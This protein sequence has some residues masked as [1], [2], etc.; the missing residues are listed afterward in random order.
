[1]KTV[2]T[3]GLLA[4]TIYF[5]PIWATENAQE[6]AYIQLND[7][8]QPKITD[9]KGNEL[10]KKRNEYNEI[11]LFDKNDEEV[12]LQNAKVVL[13]EISKLFFRSAKLTT[14][15]ML[16]L[17]FN[18]IITNS[19]EE[20]TKDEKNELLA[21]LA[22]MF[23]DIT[24]FGFKGV[25]LLDNKNNKLAEFKGFDG[26]YFWGNGTNY[27]VVITDESM[28]RVFSLPS[29]KQNEEL[30]VFAKKVYDEISDSNLEYLTIKYK[31]NQIIGTAS[32]FKNSSNKNISIENKISGQSPQEAFNDISKY[33]SNLRESTNNPPAIPKLDTSVQT[34]FQPLGR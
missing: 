34:G 3:L 16:N 12:A 17:S 20:I 9:L 21:D 22:P 31:W 19:W 8:G 18:R 28:Q 32:G 5:T 14:D 27:T 1:M 6:Q 7:K 23:A 25:N 10:Y 15:G 30:A 26:A 11:I 29:D 33:D 24:N 2:I 4:N 13:T